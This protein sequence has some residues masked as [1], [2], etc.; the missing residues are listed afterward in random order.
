VY[1][2]SYLEVC[3]TRSVLGAVF[4]SFLQ[5]LPALG[6]DFLIAPPKPASFVHSAQE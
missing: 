2:Q 6:S 3:E 4:E 5:M 1:R